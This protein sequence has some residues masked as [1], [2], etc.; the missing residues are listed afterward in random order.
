MQASMLAWV[1]TYLLHSTLLVLGAWLV[2]RR[3]G[4]RPE[5]M[6]AVWKTALVG[7]FVTATVQTGLG[8][9]PMAGRWDLTPVLAS[10]EPGSSAGADAVT[11][12]AE[13]PV[14]VAAAPVL[15]G[16]RFGAGASWPPP[17]VEAAAVLGM[18]RGARAQASASWPPPSAARAGEG[19]TRGSWAPTAAIEG[20]SASE[21]GTS[22]SDSWKPTAALEAAGA[23]ASMRGTSPSEGDEGASERGTSPSEG[24]VGE[25]QRAIA[26]DRE[27]LP[28][29][30]ERAIA[31]D[32]AGV[33]GGAERAIEPVPAIAAA[34]V[35]WSEH[36][37][38]GGN[39]EPVF[40]AASVDPGPSASA[41][42]PSSWVEVV[43]W[44]MAIA[45]LGALLGLASVLVAFAALRRQLAGRRPLA[46]G[47]L[48]S[49]L[50]GLRR[51]AGIDRP[52]R[53]TV[54][55][56]VQVPMA[57]G[58]LRPEIVVPL[59][60][61]QGL[62]PAH[63]ESLLAHE[64]A[65]VL[66]HD[67][68]WRLA[69]LLVERVFFFQPLNRLASRRVA[70][71]AEYLCDDWAARHTRQPLALATCLTEIATWVAR[72]G[73]VPATMAGPR[74]ILGRRVQRLLQPARTSA[75][76]WWLGAALGLPLL[77][78]VAV[79]PGVDTQAHAKGG[80]KGPERVV[81]I[82]EDGRRHELRPEDGGAIVVQE[83]DGELVVKRLD[84]RKAAAAKADEGASPRETRR[85]AREQE[86]A[87]D[88]ARREAR[89]E[90]R[91]AF[92]A[93][94]ARGEAA[95]SRD[96]VEAIL[97]RARVASGDEPEH[98]EVRVVVPGHAELHGRVPVDVD[99]IEDGIEEGV[100]EALQGLRALEALEGL[101][102]LEGI[103]GLEELGPAL[104]QLQIELEGLEDLGPA[105]EHLEHELE[106]EG[107]DVVIVHPEAGHPRVRVLTREQA[108]ELHRHRA[109]RDH[110]RAERHRE[111]HAEARRE[112][113]R[114]RQE[115]MRRSA[116][117]D[118]AREEAMRMREE[119]MRQRGHHD[120]AKRMHKDA[121]R[122]QKEAIRREIERAHRE[123]M[124]NGGSELP[125]VWVPAPQAPVAWGEPV[126][127]PEAWA[128][129]APAP[130]AW[131]FAAPSPAPA[132]MPSPGKKMRRA[133][134][135][136]VA[137]GA[138]VMVRGAKLHPMP[139]APPAP[140]PPANGKRPG[141]PAPPAM[142]RA[143]GRARMPKAPRAPLPPAAP[144]APTPP[145]AP[146][147]GVGPVVQ[148]SWP[149]P[150]ATSPVAVEC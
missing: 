33:P 104:E 23:S 149:P 5:R 32:L 35:V 113:A 44:V 112:A 26:D 29:Q 128:V 38:I 89:K 74:S 134:P 62:P 13:A 21:R 136:P 95:P 71:S 107:L 100:E 64:L 77:A 86:R 60:A 79:A 101:E 24:D 56:R 2:E 12:P 146:Q 47:T 7:G 20:A 53:L 69:A 111:H 145:S 22:P 25:A 140:M 18:E 98:V 87:S 73:P 133:K 17:S 52:V 78:V 54:A 103:E 139:P 150:T 92:R 93:A 67:P 127:A 147:P 30:A 19:R 11:A 41:G 144:S 68:A 106:A 131:G 132:P 72:T 141:A 85:A 148:V 142:P 59:K 88:K 129:P 108:R 37:L 97:R 118:A 15:A 75:R 91:K 116:E 110:A 109:E 83:R 9:A 28:G 82:D 76:P 81:V 102:H 40:A 48:P 42:A 4:D 61:A 84:D 137:P 27:G 123:R 90:L 63:Q 70:Q 49:L 80:R 96:E 125:T 122:M 99:A 124:R 39:R 55:P 114:G 94:K 34:P 105:L 130:E 135:V 58:V 10:R 126:P 1:V 3:W 6:S 43:P 66:R 65:H 138:P 143:P 36:A 46:E 51:R 14:A 50:D 8:I 45:G 120:A 117:H 115:G 31:E 121:K 119:I 57:V 16:A